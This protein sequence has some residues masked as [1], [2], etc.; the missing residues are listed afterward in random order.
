MCLL[1]VMNIACQKTSRSKQGIGT[2]EKAE[3]VNN[4]VGDNHAIGGVFGVFFVII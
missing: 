2:D 1:M 3:R 4:F